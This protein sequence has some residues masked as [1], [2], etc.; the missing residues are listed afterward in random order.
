LSKENE[1]NTEKNSKLEVT[2]DKEKQKKQNEKHAKQVEKAK[3]PKR[4]PFKWLREARSEFKKV[5]WPTRTQVLKN[6][7]VVLTMLVIA[8]IAIWG[9]DQLL[10]L[11]F[12]LVISVD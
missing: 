10:D 9:L 2:T 12:K 3:T 5:T 1:K 4:S 8:G 6:T 11:L 7:S